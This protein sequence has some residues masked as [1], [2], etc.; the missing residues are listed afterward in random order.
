MTAPEPGLPAI[1]NDRWSALVLAGGAARRLGGQDKPAVVV[2]G[3]TLLER[4]LGAASGAGVRVVVGPR[5]ALSQDILG[6]G[7]V[8]WR[9]ED[10]PGGGPVAAIAAGLDAVATPYV[11][12][13]AADLPFLTREELD[14]LRA[15]AAGPTVDV[16]VLVD[17]R[18]RQ[19]YLAAMWRTSRLRAALPLDPVGRPVRLLFAGRAVAEIPADARACLDCDEPDDLARA[20]GWAALA[21]SAA[22]AAAGEAAGHHGMVPSAADQPAARQPAA[23]QPAAGDAVHPAPGSPAASAASAAPADLG[24]VL[25]GWVAEVCSALGLDA[26]ALDVADLLDLTRDVAHGVARPAAPLTAFLVGLGAGGDPAAVGGA[27]QAVR[28]LL[29][30]RAQPIRPGPASSR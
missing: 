24:D 20:R 1:A 8:R 19:Q 10:P 23:R 17:P 29:A 14:R 15:A 7:P 13:L 9:R 11:A 2:G 25:D 3:S 12:V 16:A 4:V 27:A 21:D 22:P 30:R 26:A 18:G 5:R 28:E 6:A